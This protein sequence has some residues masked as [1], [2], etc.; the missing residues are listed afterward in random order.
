M[1]KAAKKASDT[2]LLG[3]DSS[4]SAESAINDD[5]PGDGSVAA[6]LNQTLSAL[7]TENERMIEEIQL[8]R[9]IHV[10]N[11]LKKKLAGLK[12]KDTSPNTL[13]NSETSLTSMR[14]D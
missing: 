8:Q 12:I 11:K 2:D 6:S 4:E 9:A 10:N 14:K 3:G 13:V 7:E 1:A 5:E